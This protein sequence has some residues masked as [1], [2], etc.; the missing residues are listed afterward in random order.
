MKITPAKTK[1][2]RYAYERDKNFID[3][4]KSPKKEEDK[5]K[6]SLEYE[7]KPEKHLGKHI[8]IVV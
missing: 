1:Y 7:K 4:R 3:D 5:T 6:N 2:I 8:N